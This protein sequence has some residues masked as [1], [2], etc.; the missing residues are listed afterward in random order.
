[1]LNN[2]LTEYS[3]GTAKYK[4]RTVAFSRKT[5]YSKNRPFYAVLILFYLG[6]Q[7]SA[8]KVLE[9]EVVVGNLLGLHARPSAQLVKIASGFDAEVSVERTDN[10]DGEA[11]CRS[12]LSLLMLAATQGTRLVLRATG[13]Q[14]EEA[15]K[16]VV[17]YFQANFDEE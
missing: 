15:F 12:V 5:V 11:D 10:Q 13:P 3:C 9:Q 17:A 2:I 6:N 16:A 14:A 7:M 4:V 8:K 1:M